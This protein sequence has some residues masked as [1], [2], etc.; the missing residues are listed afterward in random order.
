M[1]KTY[2]F[3]LVLLLISCGV[4]ERKKK[5]VTKQINNPSSPAVASRQLGNHSLFTKEDIKGTWTS[6][7]TE[8]ASFSIEEDSI[9]FVDALEY[10]KYE[11]KNDTLIYIEDNL[12]F[13][14]ARVIKANKDSLVITNSDG[15]RRLCRFND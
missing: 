15:V 6:G 7:E 4:E 9:L 3:A 12:P 2:A 1:K 11:F 13:F 10:V 8:N 14:R 5:S